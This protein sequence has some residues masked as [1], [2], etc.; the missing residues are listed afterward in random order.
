MAASIGADSARQAAAALG[1]YAA[2]SGDTEAVA[3]QAEADAW[4][5]LAEAAATTGWDAA[6]DEQKEAA[7]A[8]AG[9]ARFSRRMSMDVVRRS[10]RRH[11]VVAGHKALA[12]KDAQAASQAAT[13]AAELAKTT[14]S[15]KMAA[16]SAETFAKRAQ[17]AAAKAAGEPPKSQAAAMAAMAAGAA[18]RRAEQALAQAR[19]VAQVC[20]NRPMRNKSL[21][22]A[23]S[24]LSQLAA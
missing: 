15:A 12:Q 5:R 8:A 11:S 13:A 14:P 10:N 20:G 6:D 24:F 2:A 21:W 19:R 4:S 3:L 23:R 16:H 9:R 1:D 17:E 7:E 18:K 22:S